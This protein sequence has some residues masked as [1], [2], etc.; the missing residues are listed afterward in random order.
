MMWNLLKSV[1]RIGTA[2]TRYY[3][4]GVE[5]CFPPAC[6]AC[7]AD[8]AS[9]FDDPFES[10]YEAPPHLCQECHSDFVKDLS[11]LQ[12][13]RC[14]APIGPFADHEHGC[15]ECRRERFAFHTVHRLG[16]YEGILREAVIRG[17]YLGGE[18]LLR[19]LAE[20]LWQKTRPRM[21]ESEFELVV[22]VPQHWAQRMTRQHHAPDIL[23]ETWSRCL[24]IPVGLATLKKVRGTRKQAKLKRTERFENQQGVF[25]VKRHKSVAGK[26]VLI[27]DD[28]LTTGATADAAA[29]ALKDAGAKHVEI[30]VLAR[31]LGH[32]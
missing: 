25:R 4:G 27:A 20:L 31:V 16:I 24:K 3:R 13:L 14:G 8:L 11:Q 18:P 23:A 28:V 12:C 32:H 2:W 19:A 7:G 26:C 17:K 15:L 29:K 10:D 21:L 30:A 9:R 5:F 1:T 22:P 6:V